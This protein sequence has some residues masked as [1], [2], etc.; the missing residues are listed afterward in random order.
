MTRAAICREFGKP[1]TIE[2][3]SLEEPGAQEVLVDIK[4]CAICHSDIS[5]ML[6]EWGGPLPAVYGH[7]AAGVVIAA[8]PQVSGHAPGDRVLVTLVR[9]CGE[10]HY[11][12]SGSMVMCEGA[13][14]APARISD[15][16]GQPLE[17]AMH[18]GAFAERAVVHQSQ[19]A[20]LPADLPFDC[21][22]LLACGVITGFGAVVNTAAIKP[23][24]SVAVI[25]CGGVGLNAVQGAALAGAAPIVA[26][27]LVAA[28]RQAALGFGATDALDPTDPQTVERI[29]A[30]TGGRGVDAAIVTVGAK[31]AIDKATGYIARNGT[32]VI[33][34]MPPDGVMASYDPCLLASCNH[35]I[36][37][38]KMG[39]T[40]IA[41]DIPRLI[42]AW[43][44]GRLK[45][46]E[47][48]SG[49]YRLDQI[50]EAVAS[51]MDGGALR[52][53]IVFD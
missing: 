39:E 19:L 27:D 2:T 52:N 21:A 28:K 31:A 10:C 49:R 1:L 43:R 36:T 7:E 13:F 46:D 45:L 47:L 50:N 34:G 42:D 53:V 25:G 16:S 33:V 48:I 41:R 24:Q 44:D 12:A 30:L 35:R 38:S 26:L 51:V 15:E 4:A 23:G 3:I 8:G 40:V 29:R 20:S 14:G 6:G 37:G 5:Y 32:A 11:C 9:A 17:K 18:C 22:S